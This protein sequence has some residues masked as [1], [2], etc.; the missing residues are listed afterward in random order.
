MTIGTRPKGIDSEEQSAR[1][2]RSMFGRIAPRYDLANRVLSFHLDRYWRW[3]TVRRVAA[4][5][6]RPDVRVLDLCCGSG[7]LTFALE[8]GAGG[9]ARPLLGSDFCHPMLIEARRKGGA[10]RS[11]ARFFEGDAMRLPV[12]DA[13]FD[14]VTAAFGFRNLANYRRGLEEMVRVLRPGGVAAILEFSQPPNRVFNAGYQFYFRRVLPV[15]GGLVSGSREAYTYLPE[16]VEKFPDAAEM[17]A[18]MKEAG[19]QEARF[20][21]FTFGIVALHIGVR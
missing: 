7:D 17:V 20:E 16:S 8:A 2:V 14:L 11:A 4:V 18:R 6:A 1:W 21:Y 3:R 15:I 12:P 10:R 13:S 5:L 19:F 9:P